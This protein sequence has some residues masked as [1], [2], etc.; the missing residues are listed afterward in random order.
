MIYTN[1]IIK[2][3]NLKKAKRQKIFRI[4]SFPFVILIIALVLYAGYMKYIKHEKDISVLGFR[5]YIVITGSMQPN[6]NIG[7]MIIVK[8]TSKENIRVGDVINFIP[9]NG[10]DTITHRIIEITE[11]DGET[12]Y[13]TKGDNNSGEDGLINYNQVQGVLV[14]KISKLGTIITN[15]LTGTGIAI[16]FIL[17]I[18]SYLRE[19]KKEEKRIAREESRKLYNIPKYEKEDTI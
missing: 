4:I 17:V 7:D 18:F 2:K 1:E 6:Y 19:S 15:I 13:R 14:F 11:K 5:I 3:K 16:I 10:K 9:E 12:L 8:E